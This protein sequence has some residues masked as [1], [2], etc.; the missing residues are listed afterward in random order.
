M[1]RMFLTMMAGFAELERN[2]TSER[3]AAALAHKKRRGQAYAPTP[4][5][6]D[7]AGAELV[8]NATEGA[9]ISKIQHR[10]AAGM[11]LREIAER[12][13]V[14]GIAGKNGGRWHPSTVRYVLANDLHT[15]LAQ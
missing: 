4:F 11:T 14:A 1:G 2:L 5:G 8:A 15:M 3:T 7:P 13:N 10:R 12:L 9:T 6:F